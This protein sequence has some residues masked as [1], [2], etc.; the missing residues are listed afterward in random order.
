MNTINNKS[1]HEELN[2]VEDSSDECNLSLSADGNWV[3]FVVDG[4]QIASFHV[5]YVRKVLATPEKESTKRT[6]SKNNDF[7]PSI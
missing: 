1:N 6:K 5:N 4:K 2:F 7:S 3:R